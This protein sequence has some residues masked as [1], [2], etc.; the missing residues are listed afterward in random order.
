MQRDLNDANDQLDD[1]LQEIAALKQQQTAYDN[2]IADQTKRMEDM[3]NVIESQAKQV[4]ELNKV[5]ESY[6]KQVEDSLR[7]KWK[8]LAVFK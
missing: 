3:N 2:L 8:Q 1:A 7:K 6:A 4:A 5:I